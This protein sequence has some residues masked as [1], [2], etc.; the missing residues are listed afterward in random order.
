[1]QFSAL[2]TPHMRGMQTAHRWCAIHVIHCVQAF[3]SLWTPCCTKSLYSRFD[4]TDIAADSGS[5]WTQACSE[6]VDKQVTS[7]SCVTVALQSSLLRCRCRACWG[8]IHATIMHIHIPN[9]LY[10]LTAV[11]KF[12][13][14]VVGIQCA[15]WRKCRLFNHATHTTVLAWSFC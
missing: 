11:C 7:N 5:C 8:A 10:L 9:K 3:P 1:M 13:I 14:E 15:M 6:H 12:D 2:T 4:D